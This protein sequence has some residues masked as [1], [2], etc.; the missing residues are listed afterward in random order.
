[1]IFATNFLG[2]MEKKKEKMGDILKNDKVTIPY[3]DTPCK[4]GGKFS[5][6]I[7][8]SI[9]AL[10]KFTWVFLCFRRGNVRINNF[11]KGQTT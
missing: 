10:K 9:L 4:I 7:L 11:F 1:M 2:I 6:G 5:F 8:S 3:F